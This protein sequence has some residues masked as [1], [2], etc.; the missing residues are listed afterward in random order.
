[1]IFRSRKKREATAAVADRG[2]EHATEHAEPPSGDIENCSRRSTPS[3]ARTARRR[4]PQ[5][6][7][8]ILQ[9][10]HTAGLQLPPGPRT[11]PGNPE[12][13]FELLATGPACLRPAPGELTPELLR[14]AVLRGGSLLVRGLV[15]P[16]TSPVWS[17]G[18]TAR[19]RRARG[20]RVG[21]RTAPTTRSLSPTHDSIWGPSDHGSAN[22]RGACGR[23]L[24]EGHVRH[25][26]HLRAKRSST[27]WLPSI[28]AS[29]RRSRSTS[30]PFAGSG[31][32]PARATASGTRTEPSSGD[33]RAL[34]VWLSLS[35]CGDV[36]PGLDIVPRRIDHVVP[37]RHRGG[38]VR[39]VGRRARGRGGRG[40]RCDRAADLRARR[41]A[42]VR[43]ALPP[44]DGGRARRCRTRATRSRAG[45]SARRGSRANTLRWRSSCHV[46]R[47]LAQ[48]R[49]GLPLRLARL[50]EL[51]TFPSTMFY[52]L[53]D[54]RIHPAYRLTWPR[55]IRLAY[56]MWRTTRG[57][58]HRH[59]LQGPPGDGGQAARD[60]T[61]GGGRGRGVR[62]LPRRLDG[63]P[64]AGLRR[65]GTRTDRVR[66]L[67]GASPA[68]CERQVREGRGDGVPARRARRR[69][70]ER[71][72]V[73][74]RSSAAASA[75]DGSAT[76]FPE[77]TEPIVLAFLDVDYQ[78]SLD[79][80]IRN[81]WPHLTDRGYV[82]IDEYV[83]TDYCA[84]FLVGAL[85]ADALRRDPPGLIGAGSGVGV[86]QYYLGP[87]EEWNWAAEVPRARRASPTRAR[88][89]P[90]YWALLP[91]LGAARAVGDPRMIAFGRVDHRSRALLAERSPDLLARERRASAL[92]QSGQ[93]LAPGERPRPKHRPQHPLLTRAALPHL[94]DDLAVLDP[95]A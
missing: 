7:E 27:S 18:W 1:M 76:R 37:D 85:L 39:L 80:C 94:A 26:R 69:A 65:R 20:R 78:A 42:A 58:L 57:S 2:T 19:S 54:P 73:R 79:D 81:L 47:R 8:R 82:F 66:L 46:R 92:A 28:S 44:L 17:R 32:R 38:H 59:L 63:E 53:F 5:V 49:G 60:P 6:E 86:G 30:A 90:G 11:A 62:L 14:A 22:E 88:T 35:H 9:L 84:L 55:K 33:V 36:A 24:P 25:A 91:R 68:D 40:R 51:V 72:Q 48:F 34:N 67:R 43:R 12:P 41:R 87:F 71:A 15:G 10:R 21:R 74:R 52:L 50:W 89:S 31:R 70:G 29:A 83:L 61:R 64:V 3:P 4:I 75:R 23:R 45:S 93:P 56:R 77:H 13:A 95:Q 16:G